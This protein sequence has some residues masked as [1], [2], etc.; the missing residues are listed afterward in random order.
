LN[1]A[2]SHFLYF[3]YGSNLYPPRLSARAPSARALGKAVLDAH[4][5]LFHKLG[6]DGSGKCD[7]YRSGDPRDRVHG[8]VYRLAEAD[9]GA[10][11]RAESRGVGYDAC[12][13]SVWHRGKQVTVWTYRALPQAIAPELIPFDWYLEL[14]LA[15]ARL[16][17]LP[18]T[19]V[20]RLEGVRARP[21]PSRL[22]A[23]P[24]SLVPGPG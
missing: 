19:Y 5:L 4:A 14:V 24:I 12:T 11:D 8:A 6:R 2:A 10:L 7:A 23:H 9:R 1:G 17:R 13:V 18:A 16:H 20:A 3:A 22:R 21:D 15:G